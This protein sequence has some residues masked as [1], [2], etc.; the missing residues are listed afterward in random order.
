MCSTFRKRST[1]IDAGRQRTPTSSGTAS[2]RTNQYFYGT[3]DIDVLR[4][5]G[6][7]GETNAQLGYNGAH[8][9][10]AETNA[11]VISNEYINRLVA[12][13]RAKAANAK[14]VAATNTVVISTEYINR[15]VTE[16]RTNNPSVKAVDSRARAATLDVEA[17]RTWEDPMA[18]VGGSVFS[19][20]GFDPAEE[21]DLVNAVP[22]APR[23]HV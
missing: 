1:G 20:R 2:T 17:V 15:L 13:A 16:A 7:R 3:N 5:V 10:L 9:V 14:P 11:V 4:V 21:G 6:P 22:N 19:N 8:Q 23:H 12:D 18:M